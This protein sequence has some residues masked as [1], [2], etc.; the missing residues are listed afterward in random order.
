MGLGKSQ[1]DDN[2][3]FRKA[4]ADYQQGVVTAID[5]T[6]GLVTVN[7]AGGNV[8]MPMVG[9]A[10]LVGVKVW[11]GYFG[12]QKP[13]CLGPVAR[14]PLG[15]TQAV[16]AGN[17]IPVLFDDGVTR[18]VPYLG[19][20]PGSGSLVEVDWDSGG[21]IQGVVSQR[22]VGAVPIVP[23]SA[24]T[25]AKQFTFN[26]TDSGNW[27]ND[28]SYA[29]GLDPWDSTSNSG[30]Y[31]YGD[32]IPDTVP[33]S[34]VFVSGSLQV[35]LYEFSNQFPSSLAVL[36]RHNLP[37]KSGAPGVTDGFTIPDC[38]GGKWITLPDSWESLFRLGTARGVGFVEGAHGFHKYYRAGTQNSG[39]IIGT[40]KVAA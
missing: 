17:V 37:T 29:N 25:V 38:R 6:N 34:G 35:F 22:P 24:G 9:V 21:I 10:P 13:I 31:F 12:G 2:D 23:P 36:G 28:A 33:D 15:V 39:A 1:A 3:G 27:F 8:P 30:V 4:A 5:W 11:V 7:V 16:A 40:W 14:S 26:P 18:S 19:A 32:T 20:A